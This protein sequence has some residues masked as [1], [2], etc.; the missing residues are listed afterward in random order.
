[1]SNFPLSITKWIRER[2][3]EKTLD[4]DKIAISHNQK[5]FPE[6]LK[7]QPPNIKL[8]IDSLKNLQAKHKSVSRKQG[9][10]FSPTNWSSKLL[11]HCTTN[12]ARKCCGKSKSL[13]SLWEFN[14]PKLSRWIVGE[15]K[16]D[17]KSVAGRQ[18]VGE[19]KNRQ[20]S[21]E[22]ESKSTKLI[23]KFDEIYW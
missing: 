12:R 15:E 19:F 17:R 5:A 18:I 2:K 9:R 22:S 10:D 11:F 4:Y 1:M 23:K 13:R 21:A 6:F 3:K 16:T 20:W 8:S 7:F 14:Q